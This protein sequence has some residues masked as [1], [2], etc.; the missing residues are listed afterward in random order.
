MLVKKATHFR[1]FVGLLV[2]LYWGSFQI[3]VQFTEP[4]SVYSQRAVQITI[5]ISG[6][7]IDV[8]YTVNEEPCLMLA[9]IFD[10]F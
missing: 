6:I 2:P 5:Y 7:F 8:S 10:K 9:A 1:A 4:F 3:M